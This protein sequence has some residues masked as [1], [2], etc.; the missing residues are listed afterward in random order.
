MQRRS[1]KILRVIRVCEIFCLNGFVFSIKS[2]SIWLSSFSKIILSLLTTVTLSVFFA[3]PD[4][5][6]RK[7]AMEVSVVY[8]QVWP[9]HRYRKIAG[10]L[11]TGGVENQYLEGKQ[12]PC[13]GHSKV[14]VVAIVVPTVV[15]LVALVCNWILLKKKRV[16]MNKWPPL[17]QYG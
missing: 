6:R 5:R 14:P 8:W 1:S 9:C 16:W 2:S 17:P 12:L 3:I 15:A 13:P 10:D 11:C 7:R 4:V